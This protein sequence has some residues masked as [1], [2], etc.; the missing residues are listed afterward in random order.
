MRTGGPICS[1]FFYVAFLPSLPNG[2]KFGLLL[3]SWKV[4]KVEIKEENMVYEES[5]IAVMCLNLEM[6][7]ITST[8]TPSVGTIHVTLPKC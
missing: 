2:L 3:V 5:I 6:T 4:V 8:Q 7:Y 1:S